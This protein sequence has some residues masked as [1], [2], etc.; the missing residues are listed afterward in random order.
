MHAEC[1]ADIPVV[2]CTFKNHTNFLANP[3]LFSYS[4]IWRDYYCCLFTFLIRVCYITYVWLSP[5]SYIRVLSRMWIIMSGLL[6]Q[7]SCKK[8]VSSNIQFDWLMVK[9]HSMCSINFHAVKI[10]KSIE[11]H[12]EIDRLHEKDR[13]SPGIK[14]MSIFSIFFQQ[15]RWPYLITSQWVL[16]VDI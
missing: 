6:F 15:E 1:R 9:S 2:I 14:L 13:Q 5:F 7:L 4:S 3:I 11:Y 10:V 8:G 16:Y 12:L